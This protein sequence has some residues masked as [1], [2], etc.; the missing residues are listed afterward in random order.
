MKGQNDETRVDDK[1]TV[2]QAVRKSLLLGSAALAGGFMLAGPAMAQDEDEQLEE[3]IVTGSRLARTGFD[4]A[5]AMDVVNIRDAISLGY[6]D[7]SDMLMSQPV[8]AG[9]DQMTAVMSGIL[10]ADGGEGVQTADLRG[11]GASRTLSLLNG[12]RVGPAGVRDGVSSFDINVIPLSGLERIEILKDGASSIYG[13]DAIGGVINYITRKG[14]GGEFNAYTQMS[15]ETGGEIFSINASYGR[16]SEK[17]YWRVTADYNKQE[18]I[19]KGD[20]SIFDCEQDYRFKEPS[21]QTRADDID[22][23][24]GEYKCTGWDA[25]SQWIYDYHTYTYYG[26]Y[27]GYGLGLESNVTPTSTRVAYDYDGSIAA[28]GLLPDRN[29]GADD[30]ADLR[31]PEGWFILPNSPIGRAFIPL[32]GDLSDNEVMVPE[33][34]RITLMLNGE[35]DV[36]DSVTLYGEALFNRRETYHE[37]LYELWTYNYTSDWGLTVFDPD[38][39]CIF[40][41]CWNYDNDYSYAYIGVGGGDPASVGW[42]GAQILDPIIGLNPG[43]TTNTVDYTRFVLGAEGDIGESNWSFDTNFQYSKSDGTYEDGVILADARYY[44]SNLI[45]YWGGDHIGRCAGTTFDRYGPDGE[46]RQADIPCV[47]VNYLD[48]E[49]LRGN[50]TQEQRDF[51]FATETG[52]TEYT[53]Q[54]IDVGF[55]NNELFS[56]PAGNFGLAVGVQ[57]MTDEIADTPGI[58]SRSGN[59]WDDT[60]GPGAA[61]IFGTYGETTTQAAYLE[62]AI[63]L[64]ADTGIAQYLELNLSARYTKVSIDDTE[65]SA[66]RDFTGDTYKIG[67]NWMINES[68]R[69]RANKGTSFRTPG[70][71]EL[72]RKNFHSYVSQNIID[73]CWSWGAA[74]AGDEITQ[75]VAANCAALGMPDNTR[76]TIGADVVTGGGASVLD[77]ETSTSDSIGV[78]WTAQGLDLRVSVDYFALE[79]NDQVATFAA[80]DIVNGCM[81]SETFPDDQLCSLITRETPGVPVE[82]YRVMTVQSSYINLDKQRV[83]GWDIEASYATELPNGMG[84]SFVTSHTIL[85]TKESES[86]EG[87]ITSRLGRAGNPKWVGNLTTRL[88]KDNW[89]AI[90]RINHV[91]GTDN[92]RPNLATSGTWTGASGEQETYYFSR[93]LESRTYHNLSFNYRFGEGWAANLSVTNV[94]DLKPPRA[95]QGGGLRIEGYGAFHSQY[96]W[97]GRRYGLNIKKTF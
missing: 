69:V 5:T 26:Y 33:R 22:P 30:P 84:L 24:T 85:D 91:D 2:R 8:L 93:T 51:L 75:E 42:T 76:S 18:Q 97:K 41:E 39:P 13:S 60:A 77:A 21:L 78:I 35:Y 88:S 55:T 1:L 9:S 38:N 43:G 50:Y 31:V 56:M 29:N 37:Y 73:P 27:Y 45:P 92:N 67:L 11:L 87:V 89:A 95:S 83:E 36:S 80:V 64:L 57:H 94:T 61:M 34:E 65:D 63:P 82:E 59:V 72:Y 4:S 79:V 3:V 14:D 25:G 44:S 52:T 49:T 53:N 90:W 58:E 66:A 16:E 32:S 7:V 71:F 86:A 28:S 81:S 74:L 20:R 46:I 23:R 96:D 19:L 54:S 17:G 6:T 15:E 10:G 70:L 40:G 62:T 68:F 48:P 12:R 47:D